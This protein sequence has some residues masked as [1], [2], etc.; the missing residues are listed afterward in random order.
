MSQIQENQGSDGLQGKLKQRHITMIA[1]GG[2]IGAGLFMGSGEGIADY[3][4]ATIISYLIAA[5]LVIVIMRMLGEMASVRLRVTGS[6]QAYAKE[7]LG[8]LAGYA[9]GWLY[10]FFWMYIIAL[11]AYL[12]SEILRTLLP[13]H[14]IPDPIVSVLLLILLTLTN[15]YSVQSFGEFEFWFAC[16][17]VTT[18]IIFLGLG[19]LIMLNLVPSVPSPGFT[20]LINADNG[21][22]MPNGI[23]SILLGSL[24]IMFAFF[25]AEI[26]VIAVR[27]SDNPNKAIH[28]VI[29]SVVWRI[30]IFYIGSIF[31]IACIIPMNDTADLFNPYAA[32]FD[33]VGI[34]YASTII[35]CV[36][37]TSVLSCLNSALY[38]N[39]RMLFTLAKDGD[40][41]RFFLKLSKRGVPI[42]AVVAST[43]LAYVITIVRFASTAEF[44][45]FSFIANASGAI[46]LLVYLLI[47]ITEIVLRRRNPDLPY[48][49]KVWAFPYVS[50]A[51]IA[52]MVITLTS[53]FFIPPEI[54]SSRTEIICTLALAAFIVITYFVG[55][56][57]KKKKANNNN[58][59]N[60]AG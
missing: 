43:S 44:D 35:Q 54:G 51:A 52:I 39:S 5:A 4:P 40:A 12:G 19:V 38:T 49:I 22:F 57:R 25:G 2:V 21:G 7:G 31:I 30:L 48:S 42:R 11:E 32:I 20:N 50:Y 58:S 26:G 17:K 55:A 34:P 29:N 1:I 59:L 41:P 6:F 46:A 53:M 56:G 13:D 36:V 14:P 18:I 28:T 60:E 9:I 3:G 8:P 23:L 33:M 16:I 15:C 37:L 47:A 24:F 10:Y 45:M 27:E